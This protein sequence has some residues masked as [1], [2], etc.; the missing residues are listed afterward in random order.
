MH[1]IEKSLG[2]DVSG[3]YEKF[4]SDLNKHMLS[5]FSHSQILLIISALYIFYCIYRS[6]DWHKV[7]FKGRVTIPKGDPDVLERAEAELRNELHTETSLY[8]IN[9]FPQE[10][11]TNEEVV[12]LLK[13]IKKNDKI[14]SY[15]KSEEEI[16]SYGEKVA[17]ISNGKYYKSNQL[18][19]SIF[20]GVCQC[21]SEVVQMLVYLF[22]GGDEECGI[23]DISDDDNLRNIVL[24]HRESARDSKLK[25]NLIAPN[26]FN[27]SL[28]NICEM[29]DVE[30]RIFQVNQD[31][32][33]KAD[34]FHELIDSNT[35]LL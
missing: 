4:T 29:L 7:F 3:I 16:N 15:F 20:P 26:T 25:P 28:K 19:F 1:N 6:I 22:K 27:S 9:G 11:K 14:D 34:Q 10:S 18:H 21:E 8:K 24:S 13:E 31:C 12:N 35:I 33:V 17:R 2:L 23:I 32:T 30:V 5:N